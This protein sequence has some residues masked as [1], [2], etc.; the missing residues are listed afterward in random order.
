M[1]LLVQIVGSC[2]MD[3]IMDLSHSGNMWT[4]VILEKG[5]ESLRLFASILLIQVNEKRD[6]GGARSS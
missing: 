3:R 6:Y 4:G 2:K 5:N 1:H